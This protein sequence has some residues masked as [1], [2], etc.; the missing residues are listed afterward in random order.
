[1]HDRPCVNG[2]WYGIRT[3]THGSTGKRHSTHVHQI[4]RLPELGAAQ[5]REVFFRM[6][7]A[8][9]TCRGEMEDGV[10]LRK[11]G[12]LFKSGWQT[13]RAANLHGV[14]I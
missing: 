7:Y 8:S 11:V 6:Q 3:R 9:R 14:L 2:M 12:P 4:A 13:S 10:Q 1:V 5:R